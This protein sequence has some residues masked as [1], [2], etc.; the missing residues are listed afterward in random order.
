MRFQSLIASLLLTL[1]L[2]NP[3]RGDQTQNAKTG[4]SPPP[5]TISELLALDPS[6]YQTNI[7]VAGYFFARDGGGG[8]FK[9]FPEPPAATNYGTILRPANATGRWERVMGDSVSPLWF[10]AM[11]DGVTDVTDRLQSMYEAFGAKKMTFIF[12][13]SKRTNDGW[14]TSGN[15]LTNKTSYILAGNRSRIFHKFNATNIIY[16]PITN[17][18]AILIQD[19]CHDSS[20]KGFDFVA[21]GSWPNGDALNTGP[22]VFIWVNQSSRCEVSDCSF[23]SGTHTGIWF[24]GLFFTLDNNS[25]TNCGF[26]SGLGYYNNLI[27]GGK[28]DNLTSPHKRGPNHARIT[29]NKFVG[30][31]FKKSGFVSG[32][33]D[34]YFGDNTAFG[35]TLTGRAATQPAFLFYVGDVGFTDDS[36]NTLFQTNWTG[37]IENNRIAG[38]FPHGIEIRSN[39]NEGNMSTHGNPHKNTN[40]VSRLVIQN[41]TIS[42]GTRSGIRIRPP[43]TS[44]TIRDNL[45]DAGSSVIIEG[46]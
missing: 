43:Q 30:G 31:T 23:T 28:Y 13:P 38:T 19:D 40:Y 2:D 27:S 39:G 34:F 29:H 36:T 6:L 35:I 9:G 7:Y 10:G 25:F 32:A 3:A 14:V 11:G 45:T 46:N 21:I 26:S 44:D 24:S 22:N 5:D 37:T 20:V 8:Y 33:N 15:R 4:N 16:A 1:A 12:P 17:S 42:G 18:D 41:N